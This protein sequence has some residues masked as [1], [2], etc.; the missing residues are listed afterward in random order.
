[1]IVVAVISTWLAADALLLAFLT[2]SA[3]PRS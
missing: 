2:R 3:Q 1:M